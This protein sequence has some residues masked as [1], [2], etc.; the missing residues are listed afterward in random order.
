[1]VGVYLEQVDAQTQEC[2]EMELLEP[3][4]LPLVTREEAL[5]IFEGVRK[6]T[7]QLRRTKKGG[8]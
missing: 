5:R 8:R 4:T 2:V 1:M 3:I 7:T 6:S